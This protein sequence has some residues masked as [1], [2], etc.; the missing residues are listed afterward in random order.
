MTA[1]ILMIEDDDRLAL[2]VGDY[3]RQSGY[4]FSHC[5]DGASGLLHLQ[6]IRLI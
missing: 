1:Q 4:V 2:M 6:K 3:L 5:G